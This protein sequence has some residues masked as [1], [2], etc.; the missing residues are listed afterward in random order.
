MLQRRGGGDPHNRFSGGG[1]KSGGGIK[2]GDKR[3]S[4]GK[5]ND[6]N[7]KGYYIT[8]EIKLILQIVIHI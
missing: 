1:R 2:D 7:K 3:K 8:F 4:T 6:E 5:V